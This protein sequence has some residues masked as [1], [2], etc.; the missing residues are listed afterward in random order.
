VIATPADSSVRVPREGPVEITFS[1]GMERATVRDGLRLYPPAPDLSLDWHGDR[2]RI[3]WDGLLDSATT[4]QLVLS[5]GA[6]DV[7]GVPL[8]TPLHIRFSTGDSLDP[9]AI[10]GVLR[11]RK[12]PTKNVPMALYADSAG[13]VPDFGAR[14]PLY[15]TETD[16]TGAYAFTAIRPD[17]AYGVYALYDRNRDGY[18]DP[19]ADLIVAHEGA[20]RLTPERAVA[21]SIN[22]VAVDPLEPAVIS[23]KIA[24]PDSTERYRIEARAESVTTEPGRHVERVGR[25]AYVLRVAAGRYRL[26]GI[27]L[28][29]PG[30]IPPRLEL[31]PGPVLDARPEAELPGRDFEFPPWS[32]NPREGEGGP[33]PR[34]QE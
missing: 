14:Q 26:V 22:L 23:G 33:P 12:L 21:D 5:A 30:G 9:G 8:G 17:R 16:T 3:G 4:Y 24:A 18:I 27:R 29:G 32:E 6:R 20:I 13:A 10:R 25:G 19:E 31:P 2:L 7:H 28:A 34:P 1:E 15:S 11:A